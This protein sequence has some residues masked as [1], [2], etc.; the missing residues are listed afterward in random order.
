MQNDNE[1]ISRETLDEMWNFFHHMQLLK[2]YSPVQKYQV[3]EKD[4]CFRM[5]A[6]DLRTD[7]SC[8]WVYINFPTDK[9]RTWH[10]KVWEKGIKKFSHTA[11][12][13]EYPELNYTRFGFY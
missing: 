3:S 2:G 7:M 4:R 13:K 8:K 6:A 5:F 1:R 11:G 10:W 9:L 12:F